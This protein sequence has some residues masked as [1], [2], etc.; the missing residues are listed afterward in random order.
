MQKNEEFAKQKNRMILDEDVGIIIRS[1]KDDDTFLFF[2]YGHKAI[3]A[4]YLFF[5]LM[6]AKC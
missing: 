1:L 3:K 4:F 2:S 5:I 6:F